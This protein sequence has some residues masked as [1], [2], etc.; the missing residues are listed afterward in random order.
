VEK[1]NEITTADD[2]FS[3]ASGISITLVVT[4]ISSSSTL[5]LLLAVKQWFWNGTEQH[6]STLWSY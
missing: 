4:C 6:T 5:R 3:P 1:V 2:S